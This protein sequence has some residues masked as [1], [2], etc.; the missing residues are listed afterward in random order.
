MWSAPRDSRVQRTDLFSIGL[1]SRPSSERRASRDP[2]PHPARGW[3]PSAMP[4]ARRPRAAHRGE[5][6][7]RRTHHSY[8]AARG[9]GAAGRPTRAPRSICATMNQ[10]AGT[11]RA[12]PPH[13]KDTF[14]I[15]Q[16]NQLRRQSRVDAITRSTGPSQPT[17]WKH[18]ALP[19]GGNAGGS[20]QRAK[21]QR[22]V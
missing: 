20:P 16:K 15:A 5:R 22:R 17:P 14:D 7:G 11:R 19:F 21:T 3:G 10:A 13:H 8:R 4:G 2:Q 9:R 18:P 6:Q 1:R 12:Q